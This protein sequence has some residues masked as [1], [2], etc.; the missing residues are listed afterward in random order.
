[1]SASLEQERLRGVY[2]FC[3]T[4]FKPLEKQGQIHTAIDEDG[5]RANIHF[6][7]EHNVRH[8]IPCGGTGEFASLDWDEYC[9][10]V[11]IVREEAGADAIVM[12]GVGFN[13]PQTVRMAQYAEIIGCD[14]VMLFPPAIPSS[15]EGLYQFH[16]QLAD[17]IQIVIMTYAMTP[18]SLNF[19]QKLAEF[20]QQVII[21]DSTRDLAWSRR[22][23]DATRDRLL[24]ICEGEAIA[25][26][27]FLHSLDG[28]TTG[29][30]NFLPELSLHMYEAAN[31]G[32]YETVVN[33]QQRLEP[34][35]RL[36]GRPGNHVPVVKAALDR[37]GLAGGIVRSPLLP[38]G[39][40]EKTE[41]VEILRELGLSPRH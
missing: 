37:L 27:Y 32:D 10:V 39:E 28:V 21:K 41:L 14:G 23:I 12:P 35:N 16:Q 36:R 11:Q 31:N 17:S 18:L 20:D 1:M 3:P 15:A 2:V 19:L 30:A 25:P 40:D 22:M 29:V 33:I 34:L 4:P 6:L 7:R 5:L 8:I 26:Y 13:L 38:V 9:K 24:W